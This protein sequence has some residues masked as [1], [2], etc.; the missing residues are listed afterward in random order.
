MNRLN[1][2]ME[3]FTFD[4]ICRTKATKRKKTYQKH[5]TRCRIRL[6]MKSYS[7]T[8]RM[9][10]YYCCE[11]IQLIY[12]KTKKH[13]IYT[14]RVKK[15]CWPSIWEWPWAKHRLSNQTNHSD[16]M[17]KKN[18]CTLCN[19]IHIHIHIQIRVKIYFIFT[20][21]LN[22]E[23]E[24]RNGTNNNTSDDIYLIFVSL[25]VIRSIQKQ[26]QSI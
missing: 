5:A 6:T 14:G 25:M 26:N 22:E 3:N 15:F 18:R 7:H 10:S 11:W 13:H 16:A 2:K 4:R 23:H 9:K 1:I 24:L 17:P 21:T 12:T 8:Y 19:H 20:Y